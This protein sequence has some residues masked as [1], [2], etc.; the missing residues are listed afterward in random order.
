MEE[1]KSA[2]ASLSHW[3]ELEEESSQKQ[4]L[5]CFYNYVLL[6]QW[7]LARATA[8]LICQNPFKEDSKQVLHALLDLATNPYEQ[9]EG[10]GSVTS[11]EH[12]SWLALQE[13]ESC[14]KSEEQSTDTTALRQDVE[15]RLLLVQECDGV[16][17]EES[18]LHEVYQYYQKHHG[19][20]QAYSHLAAFDSRESLPKTVSHFLKQKLRDQ[21]ATGHHLISLLMPKKRM[22]DNRESEALQGLYIQSINKLIDNLP[23]SGDRREEVCD[24]IFQLLSFYDPEP[25]WNYLQ[26]RQLFTRLLTLGKKDGAHFSRERIMEALMGRAQGYLMDEFGKL[27]HEMS[28][29]GS[30][31]VPSDLSEEHRLT[32]SL[33]TGED[34]DA[35]WQRFFV[36]CLKWNKHCLGLIMETCISLVAGEQFETLGQFLSAPELRRLKPVVLLACWTYCHSSDSARRLLDTL[37]TSGGVDIHPALSAGCKKL[38]YQ[39]SLIKWCMERARPLL[40]SSESVPSQ[41]S[42]GDRA[43][44]LLHGLETHSVLFV[45]HQSTQLAALHSQEVLRLLQNVARGS[46]DEEKKKQKN[47][48]F[49]DD[50]QP[51]ESKEPISA[52][53]EHDICI[54]RS[55][56]AIKCVMDAIVFCFEN[57]HLALMNPVRIKNIPKSKHLYKAISVDAFASVSSSE[58]DESSTPGGGLLEKPSGEEKGQKS[59]VNGEVSGESFK[60]TYHQQ[61]WQRI[62]QAR[63]HLQHLYPL[64]YRVEILEN[65][66]SLL[67]CRHSDLQDGA[68]MMEGVSDDEADGESKADS[69]ENL[70]MSIISEED[71][72]LDRFSNSLKESTSTSS[73]LQQQTDSAISSLGPEGRSQRSDSIE[74]DTPFQ[75]L[76]SSK[77]KHPR[78]HRSKDHESSDNMKYFSQ[79]SDS[80]GFLANDYVVRDVLAMLKEALVDLNA[81][82]LKKMGQVQSESKQVSETLKQTS[83]TTDSERASKSSSVP[84]DRRS[85]SLSP[86]TDSAD[87][88]PALEKLLSQTVSTSITSELLQKRVAQLTQHIHEAQWRFQLVAHEQIPRQ[89]GRVLE[90]IVMV[91]DDDSHTTCVYEEWMA[92]KGSKQA[93]GKPAQSSKTGR[94]R[95]TSSGRAFGEGSLHPSQQSIITRMLSSP[96]SLLTMSLTRNSFTQA[97][98]II[99]LLKINE[100]SREAAEV[101]FTETFNSAAKS[102]SSLNVMAKE[103]Q[104]PSASKKFS[105]QAVKNAAAAGVANATLSKFVDDLLANPNIPPLPRPHWVSDHTQDGVFGRFFQVNTT[106]AI[107]MDLACTMCQSWEQCSNVFDIIKAKG[108]LGK[109]LKQTDNQDDN[110]CRTSDQISVKDKKKGKNSFIRCDLKGSRN[111][112]QQLDALLQVGHGDSDHWTVSAMQEVSAI[113]GGSSTTRKVPPLLV[114]PPS[115]SNTCVTVQRSLLQRFRSTASSLVAANV[116]LYENSVH[117]IQVHFDQTNQALLASSRLDRQESFQIDETHFDKSPGVKQSPLSF[118]PSTSR[119]P[120]IGSGG[121]SWSREAQGK[122]EVPLLHQRM[123]HLIAVMEKSVPQAGLISLLLCGK[124]ERGMQRNYLLSMYEHVKE[125]AYLVAECESKAAEM[126]IL[127]KNYFSILQEGPVDILGRL[128]FVKRVS[129]A[130]LE[131]VASRLS[132]NLTHIIVQSCCPQI[133]SKH[134]PAL[135]C[136]CPDEVEKIGARC[137]YNGGAGGDS[138]DSSPHPEELVRNIL[139]DILSAMQEVS[140]K[141]N[142]KGIFT[143]LCGRQLVKG[144]HYQQMVTSLKS[145]QTVDLTQLDSRELRLCFFANLLNL[146]T[147]HY[148]LYN[149]K[150]CAEV[151]DLQTEEREEG[152]TSSSVK[153]LDGHRLLDMVTKL[154]AFCYRVGQLGVLSLFDL[155]YMMLHHGQN[156]SQKWKS[157]VISGAHK[158][159]PEDPMA[160][161]MPPAEPRLLFVVSD[162]CL[163]SPPVQVLECDKLRTQLDTAAKSYLMH[164][165]RLEPDKGKIS[166]P[167][168]LTALCLDKPVEKDSGQS[169]NDN[170]LNFVSITASSSQAQL[171]EQMI[172]PADGKDT[173]TSSSSPKSPSPEVTLSDFSM[174]FAYVFKMEDLAVEEIQSNPVPEA[175]SKAG[176]VHC[177]S[178]AS[179]PTSPL[180]SPFL[181][182]HFLLESSGS[183]VDTKVSMAEPASYQ[184]TPVTLDYV[185][186]TSGLVATLLTL[187]C[188]DELDDNETHF[189]DDHFPSSSLPRHRAS[190]DISVVDIRSY[191]Y[192]R[193]VDDFPILQRHLLT[194]IVPLAGAD[195][196]EISGSRD[197]VLKFVTNVIDEDVK[198]CLFSLHNSLQFLDMLHTMT[199]RLMG[200]R[201]WQGLI[202]V[203]RSIPEVVMDTYSHLQLLH[204]FVVSCWAKEFTATLPRAKPPKGGSREVNLLHQLRRMYCPNTQARVVIAVCDRLPV[205]WGLDLLGLCLSQPIHSQL[206]KAVQAKHHHLSIYHKITTCLK[207]HQ[208]RLSMQQPDITLMSAVAPSPAVVEQLEKLAK[209]EDWRYIVQMSQDDPKEVMSVLVQAGDM[210]LTRDW[211]T[212]HQLPPDMMMEIEVLYLMYLMKTN[213]SDTLPVYQA[214]EGLRTVRPGECL[215]VCQLLLQ[216]L[217]DQHKVKFITGYMLQHLAA[218]LPPDE[219]EDLRLRQIG[220]KALLCIPKSTR[221]EY[222]HL[223]TCPHLILE[224][225]LMNMKGELAGRVFKNIREDFKEI[226]DTKLHVAQD[227]F[228]TLLT[229]YARKALE[230]TV[231]QTLDSHS[232][233]VV[234]SPRCNSTG[235]GSSKDE[236]RTTPSQRRG[237][238]AVV[239]RKRNMDNTASSK[240]GTTPPPPTIQRRGSTLSTTTP[241]TVTS[242][243]AARS[244]S[245]KFI[246][247]VV[248]PTEDQWI[249]DSQASVCMVCR[250][251]RFS[252]FNRRHHCRRC[253]RVVCAACSTRRSQVRGMSARTCDECYEQ[254]FGNRESRARDEQEVYSQRMKESLSGASPSLQSPPLGQMAAQFRPSDLVQK[255]SL[256]SVVHHDVHEWKLKTDEGLNGYIRDEFYYEQAPSVALC[257]SIL[258]HHTDSHVSGQLILTMCDDL[259]TFLQPLAPGVPNLEVDYGLII[260]IIRELLFRAKMIFL[261]GGDS[262]MIAKCE[263]YQ[264]RVDLLKILLEANYPD[265]PTLQELSKMDTARRLRD[266]LIRDERLSLA[267]EVCTKCGVEATGVWQ[268]WGRACL[269]SGDFTAARDKFAHCLKAPKDKNQTGVPSRLLTEIIDLLESLPPTGVTEIQMLLSNPSNLPSLISMPVPAQQDET[270]VESVV[271][272]ECTHYL[273]TYGTYGD[274]L[275]FLLKNGYWNKAL[276]FVI[277]HRCSPDVFVE[278]ILQ[279]ALQGGEMT[280][281]IE[282]LLM[283]DSSLDQWMPHLTASCRYL[284]KNKRFHVL[285]NLQ[286]FMKDF[287]R[288]AMTCINHFYQQ[289]AQS[290]LDLAS[291]LQFLFIAQEHMQ[292]FLDPL[293]WGAVRHPTV[294]PITPPAGESPPR[295]QTTQQM[296]SQ[297]CMSKEDITRN[298]RL[299]ALQIE[300]TQFLEQCLQGS[301]A[302]EAAAVATQFVARSKASTLIPTLFGNQ[303]QRKDVVK[304]I[305]LSGGKLPAAFELVMR[306]FQELQLR[307]ISV[308][309]SVV[310]EHLKQRRMSEM[311]DLLRMT[312]QRQA[313]DDDAW[314]EIVSTALLEITEKRLEARDETEI[315][316][317]MIRKEH[318][319]LNALIMTGKLRSAY[320]MAAKT[321]RAQDISRIMAAAERMGQAAVRNIC[322]KWLEQHQKH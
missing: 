63:E 31:E 230:V 317:K 101:T 155:K 270:S 142:G 91:T 3:L 278:S 26:I 199:S 310:C 82:K 59:E 22:T 269:H 68:V 292:A 71:P 303:E 299:I 104:T 239:V 286:I 232:S 124:M 169:L 123:K 46:G 208:I 279:P 285:Y 48:H 96:D 197:P 37:W 120:S 241:V 297:M 29:S 121:S 161:F 158:L 166:L 78:H 139:Q 92:S 149:I 164:A 192:H 2:A 84:V 213:S 89:A 74:Y 150:Q 210:A 11:P 114:T 177:G 259:S 215:E 30:T 151:Q 217:D 247:P 93:D 319:K 47:V 72:D 79:S 131:K 87:F 185:R 110:N 7:E 1:S 227:Q 99:K 171:L 25:Y 302:G 94:R 90:D 56:C 216:R 222:S 316:I 182:Q 103:T 119:T 130:R 298:L 205:D 188:S 28:V 251:E 109:T 154:G 308:L 242:T 10:S 184:L 202:P 65:I 193:L 211:A 293:K 52:E 153:G 257:M 148:H 268:A 180:V 221:G 315:L 307:A 156:L 190:S 20:G 196:P 98:Q 81:V 23:A 165:V 163:S 281:L 206:R 80:C 275:K 54:Y 73:S 40:E 4:Q 255:R 290:Y 145:L 134:L 21:P 203:L 212:L 18:T 17:V 237:S 320:L 57:S 249:P 137:V 86:P 15:F 248:P 198:V 200:K 160:M 49:Q 284:L 13:Y 224:Q 289:G 176:V 204:D 95:S 175:S 170:L 45:L 266:K 271:Y 133:P 140:I 33:L 9:S 262:G 252:M 225:L 97:A 201:H 273:R 191:R 127:P 44:K 136:P 228:N 296:G 116:K 42:Y 282:Q 238:E 128:M 24:K 77:D 5:Q 16:G 260:S 108:N 146:M 291:R 179:T 76:K 100:K 267:L 250:L 51:P 264:A 218:N 274:H 64:A 305:L 254:M 301:K 107:L 43:T 35:C 159:A 70:S 304:M 195:N 243:A 207:T 263:A 106:T 309:K 189:I 115:S 174:D 167:L 27:L 69:L 287:L 187:L 226:K 178:L 6:G 147:I 41:P 19:A 168:L 50:N 62:Q 66:F 38:A 75:E 272:K 132:L 58:G 113:T 306:I 300:V 8:R 318:N 246:M 125:L 258:Q 112:F 181:P 280:R 105:L 321:N 85:R 144:E 265:L 256:S 219:L 67:F 186:E 53:Q 152:T 194:Y 60:E 235:S 172:K 313:L 118:S 138:A 143:E 14:A 214:L 39:L 231:V 234:G 157:L 253:G 34:R 233:S 288:A 312:E 126:L 12:L 209:Y 129:P 117:D 244:G 111:F 283:H 322:K 294:S 223:I 36:A 183:H 102:I 220:A 311:L 88:N 295:V 277:D 135:P 173:E 55:Y 32:L 141:Y 240:F 61:V 236:G 261:K 245:T 276:K 122:P 314:D 83:G 229:N 162:G